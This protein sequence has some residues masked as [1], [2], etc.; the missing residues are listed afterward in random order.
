MVREQFQVKIN[1]FTLNVTQTA[2]DAVRKK[3]ITKTGCRVYSDGYIGI[4]GTF[5][6]A[7]EQTWLDA[8]K[9][10]MKKIPYPY[11][12]SAGKT[13]IRNTKKACGS[14]TDFL[15]QSEEFLARIR[16]D[17]P[18]F[19]CSNKLMSVESEVS[20]HNDLG[21]DYC[22]SD[23]SIVFGL[24][25][26]HI[27]SINVFDTIYSFED[28]DPDFE[29]VYEDLSSQLTA[30]RN[31]MEQKISG[32]IPV[33][34]GFQDISGKFIESLNG[35]ALGRGVSI[36][37]DK[38]GKKVFNDDFSL[39]VDRGIEPIHASFFDV[40]GSV[41]ESDQTALIEKGQI[42]CGYADKKTADKYGMR[43]TAAAGGE[44]NSVPAL[45]VPPLSVLPSQKT[46]AEILNGRDAVFAAV[47]SGG[48]FTNE[49]QFASPV[50]MAYSIRDGKLVG[51]LPELTISGNIYDLF[52]ND[53][54]G[55]SGD[56]PFCGER[57]LVLN[58][59]VNQY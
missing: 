9:N 28:R 16:K 46:L 20:I 29:S 10:L 14:Q 3:Q 7:D 44:Y 52:G 56:K 42:R 58:M 49:G 40:E 6:E 45:S 5:G 36:F 34:I 54:F 55:Q 51:K 26:K 57:Y 23:Q 11:P 18:D 37:G 15:K 50:Q 4:S 17:F 12:P 22:N 30:F 27:K 25:V 41:L 19:I 47:L 33:V 1:S 2:V 43:N 32:K 8:E 24:V 48:D 13:R 38:I 53:Y 35:E 31:P 21:L 59:D 39:M